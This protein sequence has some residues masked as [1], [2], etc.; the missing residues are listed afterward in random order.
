MTAHGHGRKKEGPFGS[1]AP[2]PSFLER[3][4][5]GIKWIFYTLRNKLLLR[6]INP[7]FSSTHAPQWESK[8]R[9]MVQGECRRCARH[10]GCRG[11]RSYRDRDPRPFWE[12][13]LRSE[14]SEL[15]L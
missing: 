14:G 1:K 5:G 9:D 8:G 7:L 11:R 3:I 4:T 10:R 13:D 2:P 12:G 15:P 6:P